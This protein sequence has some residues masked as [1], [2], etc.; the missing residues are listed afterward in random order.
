MFTGLMPSHHGVHEKKG[1]GSREFLNVSTRGLKNGIALLDFLE[2]QN[3][4]TLSL[5]CNPFVTNKFGYTF[6]KSGVFGKYGDEDRVGA[7]RKERAEHRF[8][9]IYPAQLGLLAKKMKWYGT[10]RLW[11][12][13][14]EK[15][16]KY[17]LSE[18]RGHIPSSPYFLYVNLMEAHEPYTEQEIRD[19]KLMHRW[20]Q[21]GVPPPYSSAWK[22]RYE[23]HVSFLTSRLFKLLDIIKSEFPTS[24]VIVTSDHG[25]LLG[26]GGRCGHGQYL[27]DCL[28]R[29]PLYCKLPDDSMSIERT[30]KF[31]SLTEVPK[32]IRA[33]VEGQRIQ[34][35]S[36]CAFA[37]SFGP[38]RDLSKVS[39]VESEKEM[40]E[41][42]FVHKVKLY[43]EHG[44]GTFNLSTNELE[45]VSGQLSKQEAEALVFDKIKEKGRPE[46]DSDEEPAVFS[47]EEE[48]AISRHLKDLGY[49]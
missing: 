9:S 2:S 14:I 39:S 36:E 8:H 7:L 17:I 30:G 16:S 1:I 31:I 47:P 26:E 3:F 41:R 33:V 32:L 40:F 43:K 23:K 24:L 27:D 38:Q 42:L 4:E 45:D 22:S 11:D 21:L 10:M 5:T 34:V 28:L 12:F 19:R 29:V 18:L 6:S 49:L 13:P 46:T 35:G 37:E 48:A 20:Y 25:Q 15:G 44:A